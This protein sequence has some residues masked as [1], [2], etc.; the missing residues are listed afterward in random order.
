M[1]N[2]QSPKQDQ[3]GQTKARLRANAEQ[4]GVQIALVEPEI[5]PNTGNIARLCAATGAALHL[6]HPLGFSVSEKAVR[7]AGL[8]YWPLVNL[9][10]HENFEAFMGD[11]GLK[12]RKYFFSG[13]ARRSY[14]DVSYCPGDILVFGRE[15]RGLDPSILERYEDQLVAIPT[16]GEV[17]SLNLSNAAAIATFEALRQ[18]KYLDST[19]FK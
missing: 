12:G 1:T 16:I 15:S 7:R 19:E 18:I 10:E 6:I 17:R 11:S 4:L 5:P 3:I 14:L 9:T 2:H 13:K 8:D